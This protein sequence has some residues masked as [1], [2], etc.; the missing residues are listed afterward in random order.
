MPGRYPVLRGLIEK[1]VDTSGSQNVLKSFSIDKATL[2]YT[3]NLIFSRL[4]SGT[5]VG[6]DLEH[7]AVEGGTGTHFAVVYGVSTARMYLNGPP[8]STR[9]RWSG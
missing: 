1:H 7:F 2:G 9:S 5:G 4:Y 3:E 6:G 8:P